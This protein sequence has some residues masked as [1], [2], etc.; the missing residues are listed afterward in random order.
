MASTY[1]SNL[2]LQLMTTGENTGTWGNVTNVNLGTA[3]EE[4]IV[5]TGTVTFAS[6]DVTL[7]LS[8]SNATQTA[9]NVRLVLSG[10][11]GGARQLVVPALEKVYIVQNN[12][13]DTCTVLVSGQ[14]GVAVPAGKTMW[15]YND[16]TDVRD[17]TTYLTTLALG[18]PLPVSSGGTGSNTGVNVQSVSG[19]LPVAN[20]GTGSATAAF[21]GSLIT[22]LNATAI[23]SGTLDN[24]YTTANTANQ[25]NAI[26]VRD[27]QGS[28][29]ANVVTAS[30]FVG[31]ASGNPTSVTAGTGLTGGGS[32]GAVTLS[33]DT[34]YRNVGTY[35]FAWTAT[36]TTIL[37]GGGGLAGSNMWPGCV[38]TS[39]NF[40]YGGS[41]YSVY[42]ADGN[43]TG[44]GAQKITF[45]G[46]WQLMGAGGPPS[47]G[48]RYSSLWIR[49]A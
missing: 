28:F 47:A 30:S 1:S 12:L 38:V 26:V 43:N 40:P 32:S 44:C 41:N 31:P 24:A 42:Y 9:R 23:T 33:L 3:L 13:A 27:G 11:S 48:Q 15:L 20:G 49:I 25:A 18:T 29:S 35:I 34:T 6:A 21:N 16:G 5:G 22:N 14:T 7:T 17:V 37:D 45:T 39:Q 2:K 8:N 19:I 4:A 46:T 10:T 36:A